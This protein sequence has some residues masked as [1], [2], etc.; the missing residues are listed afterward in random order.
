[1]AVSFVISFL[2]RGVPSQFREAKWIAIITYN[3]MV[4]GTLAV[5]LVAFLELSLV[6]R[7]VI[8]AVVTLYLVGSMWGLLFVPKV[9]MLLLPQQLAQYSHSESTIRLPYFSTPLRL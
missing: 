2:V 4:L 5:L 1:M 7:F 9:R 8:E 6:V 3:N